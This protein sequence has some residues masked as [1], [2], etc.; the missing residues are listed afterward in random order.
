MRSAPFLRLF[1]YID[2]RFANPVPKARTGLMPVRLFPLYQAK[3]LRH[4]HH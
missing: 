2:A 1:Y 4:A 3:K